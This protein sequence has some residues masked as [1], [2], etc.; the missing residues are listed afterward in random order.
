MNGLTFTNVAPVHPRIASRQGRRGNTN[1]VPIVL[2]ISDR[3]TLLPAHIRDQTFM[4]AASAS[5]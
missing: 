5:C 3:L 1:T 2:Q 4:C